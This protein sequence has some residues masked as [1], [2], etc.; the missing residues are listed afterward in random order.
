MWFRIGRVV[1]DI[2]LGLLVLII[3][4]YAV[5]IVWETVHGV[6]TLRIGPQ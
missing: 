4:G 6:P 5:I 2:G 1:D 3:L